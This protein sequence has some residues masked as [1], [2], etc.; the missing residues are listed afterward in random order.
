MQGLPSG[1]HPG[2][3]FGRWGGER[4]GGVSLSSKCATF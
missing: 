2:R 1:W 3:D 4:S